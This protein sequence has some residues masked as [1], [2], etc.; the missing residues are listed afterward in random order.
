LCA[1]FSKIES[2]GQAGENTLN[3]GRLRGRGAIEVLVPELGEPWLIRLAA[4]SKRVALVPCSGIDDAIARGK[5]AE[6]SLGFATRAFFA[7]ARHVRWAHVFSTGVDGVL[8][9]VPRHVTLT[10][11]RGA[12]APQLAEHA[13]A[14]LLALTRQLHVA[15]VDEARLTTVEGQRLLIIGMGGAGRALAKKA[16]GLGMKVEAGVR[17]R[18]ALRTQLGKADAVALCV[19]LTSRTRGLIGEAE[20]SAM[21]P[22]ARLINVSRGAVVDTD[23]LTAAL[24]EGRLGGAGLDVTEPEPLPLTHPLRAMHNVVV[25]PH[26]A[27]TSTGAMEATVGLALENLRRY[28]A[29]RVLLGVV[30]RKR[31]Y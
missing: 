5:S 30:D 28:V 1:D 7:R 14:L 16:K 9:E 24:R 17:D 15:E 25:T 3:A 26:T 4:V 12:Y 23:A 19:P 29:G 22:T 8:E 2:A 10:S 11:A 18:R 20:L 27:G 6:V 31:G 13:L 21:K